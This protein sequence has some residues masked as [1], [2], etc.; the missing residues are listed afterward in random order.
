[1][2]HVKEHG[3]LDTDPE[4]EPVERIRK[5]RHKK[6]HKSVYIGIFFIYEHV[7]LSKTKTPQTLENTGF[8]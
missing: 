3:G 4:P 1:M 2:F 7:F 8:S 5:N 6:R